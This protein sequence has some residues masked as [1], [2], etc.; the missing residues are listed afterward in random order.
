MLNIGDVES[1]EEKKW[2]K[3]LLFDISKNEMINKEKDILT[4]RKKDKW[5]N[6]KI[7]KKIIKEI[8]LYE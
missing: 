6:L 7:M 5:L 8:F 3:A 2:E 1:I 4:I